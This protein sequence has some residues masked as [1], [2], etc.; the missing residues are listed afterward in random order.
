MT[1]VQT[2]ALPIW[3]PDGM[4]NNQGVAEDGEY[5]V[6]FRPAGDGTEEDGYMR[7]SKELQ[8]EIRK[9]SSLISA[10]K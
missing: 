8:G 7:S 4:D 3:Y 10:K 5:M 6:Y 1:G 9:P 2:C